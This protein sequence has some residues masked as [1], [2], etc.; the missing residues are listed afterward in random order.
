[1]LKKLMT[2]LRCILSIRHLHVFEMQHKK[3]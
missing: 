2:P 3:Y 1:M